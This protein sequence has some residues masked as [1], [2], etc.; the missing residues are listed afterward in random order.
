MSMT[1]HPTQK[2]K[3]RQMNQP[4]QGLRKSG[5]ESIL[6][7]IRVEARAAAKRWI[8]GAFLLSSFAVLFS[9]F[10]LYLGATQVQVPAQ[11]LS[12]V[13]GNSAE[14]LRDRLDDLAESQKWILLIFGG[15]AAL[16]T[17]L[18]ASFQWLQYT[19]ARREREVN[20]PDQQTMLRQVNE[21]IETVGRTL[22][23]RLREEQEVQQLQSTLEEL[24]S[25]VGVLR[26]EAEDSFTHLKDQL[27]TLI[28]WPR[29]AFTSL[30]PVQEA[31]T[32]RFLQRFST[33]PKWF[34]KEHQEDLAMGQVT[35]FAGVIAFVNNDIVYSMDLLNEAKSCRDKN[36][37]SQDEQLQFWGAFVT[38]W[39]GL[40]EKNWGKLEEARRHFR[41]SLSRYGP[42]GAKKEK[43]EWL[44]RLSL[45]EVLIY[46]QNTRAE[47][48]QIVEEVLAELGKPEE[49]E[50]TETKTMRARA[51]LLIGNGE[52]AE[53]NF[54]KARSHFQEVLH[55][56][57][58]NYYA[59]FSQ[60]L[61]LRKL[62]TDDEEAKEEFAKTL[63][64]I[65]DSGDL[66]TKKELGPLSG[67]RYVT[68]RTAQWSN[69]E[70]VAAEHRR[71]LYELLDPRNTEFNN[72]QLRIFVPDKVQMLLAEEL[73]R[74]LTE[75]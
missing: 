74:S 68:M 69:K 15:L 4:D 50:R 3:E 34:R 6:R 55:D 22:A 11:P 13:P 33:L 52:M 41:D 10:A 42:E 46:D 54:E 36:S 9:I 66:K 16:I 51:R 19:E 72:Y 47:A 2:S 60:A 14:Y 26:E 12:P 18:G 65:Q 71:R 40:V 31:T 29:I 27:P 56:S 28:R 5:N 75:I 23:F 48:K 49:S 70:D 25:T 20:E 53:G 24:Q 61:C 21:V 62:A 32:I 45:A 1:D 17:L 59:S 73:R 67:L 58:D 39:M 64:M 43:N 37:S 63:K 57:P 7:E 30:D 44:T 38:Y 8:I 35:Y